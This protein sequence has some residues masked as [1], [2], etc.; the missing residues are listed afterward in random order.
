M[1]CGFFEEKSGLA[2]NATVKEYRP[3]SFEIREYCRTGRHKICPFYFRK[4]AV[5][6]QADLKGK[7]NL[8]RV[9]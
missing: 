7:E 9:R 2:C 6:N 5:K 3:S 8:I 4:Q 1:K